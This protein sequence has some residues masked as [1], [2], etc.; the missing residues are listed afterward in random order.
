MS[1]CDRDFRGMP[2]GKQ[3]AEMADQWVKLKSAHPKYPGKEIFVNLSNA[4]SIWPSKSKRGGSE[5]WFGS[6]DGAGHFAV[7]EP[8][9]EIMRKRDES[10]N[11][12]RT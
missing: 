2:G 4:T 9:G 3:E 12:D 8:P 10:T 11:A 7:Q 5:I 1:L 6:D